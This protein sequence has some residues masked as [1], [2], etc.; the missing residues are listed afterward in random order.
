MSTYVQADRPLKVTTPLGAD[1][2]LLRGL[3]GYEA[4]SQLF[5][6]QL[7]LMAEN[8]TS[9]PF[10]KLLGQK[11]SSQLLLPDQKTRY[12]NGICS[13]ISEGSR[14]ATFTYYTMEVV[15]E[16]WFLTRKAQSRIF[17][18][19]SV[20]DILKEVLSGLDVTYELQ[21]TFQPRDYCVQYRETDFNFA[22]RVM[23][24]EGIFFFFKHTS[25]GHQLVIANTPQSHSD[26]PEKSTIEFEQSEVGDRQAD[27][28]VAW[29]KV[30]ELRSGK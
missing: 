2:L 26:L 15:P 18:Q 16:F 10:D 29:E 23:E 8:G 21:G 24:E 22:C 9:V 3:S 20:P 17:Q 27:R 12:F 19:K 4:V 14:D 28:I 13:R 7:D 11:I 25:G 1:I 5:H 6:F 30:Q